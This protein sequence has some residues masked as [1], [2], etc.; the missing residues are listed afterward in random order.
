MRKTKGSALLSSVFV[1]LTCLLFIKLY[2]QIY[3]DS[4]ENNQMIIQYLNHD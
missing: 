3:H 2:Q 4:M 1:L